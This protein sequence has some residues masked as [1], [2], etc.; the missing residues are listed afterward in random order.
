MRKTKPKEQSLSALEL[1][2]SSVHNYLK[3]SKEEN[4]GIYDVLLNMQLP[5]R[6]TTHEIVWKS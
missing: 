5:T 6:A 4:D 2:V 1:L 3:R